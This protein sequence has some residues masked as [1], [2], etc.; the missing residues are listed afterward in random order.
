MTGV[1]LMYRTIEI[2]NGD[3]SFFKAEQLTRDFNETCSGLEYYHGIQNS[4]DIVFNNEPCYHYANTPKGWA[5]WCPL[6]QTDS[7]F[8]QPEWETPRLQIR[9]DH[10]G[11]SI[12]A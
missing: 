7:T 4:V 3:F 8:P 12:D 6:I 2:Q 11:C 1:D 5:V 10:Y 9:T